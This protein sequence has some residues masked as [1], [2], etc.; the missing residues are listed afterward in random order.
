MDEQKQEL[1][2]LINQI[3]DKSMV[4]YLLSLIKKLLKEWGR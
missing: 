3:T 2:N 1:H 4:E